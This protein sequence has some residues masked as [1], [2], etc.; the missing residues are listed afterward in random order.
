[1]VG[2]KEANGILV[3]CSLIRSP[4]MLFLLIDLTD[5]RHSSQ[6]YPACLGQ[7]WKLELPT[8][9]TISAD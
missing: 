7:P 4:L 3:L 6:I 1:M 9:K 8:G 5:R 2:V